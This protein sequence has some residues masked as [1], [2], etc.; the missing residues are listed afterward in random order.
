MSLT[1]IQHIELEPDWPEHGFTFEG[2]A[3]RLAD[4]EKTF[5]AGSTERAE[6]YFLHPTK[7]GVKVYPWKNA[8]YLTDEHG[9]AVAPTGPKPMPLAELRGLGLDDGKLFA[10]HAAYY[11][12]PAVAPHPHG[13]PDTLEAQHLRRK[14]YDEV[15]AAWYREPPMPRLHGR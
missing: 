12:E 15:T 11:R 1:L 10:E 2:E 7:P 5:E 13:E 9:H 6:V 3:I 8:G 14:V 4:V